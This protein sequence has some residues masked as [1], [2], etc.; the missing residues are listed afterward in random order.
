MDGEGKPLIK[1]SEESEENI[2]IE[3]QHTS[4][5]TALLAMLLAAI[6]FGTNS[7]ILK[8]IHMDLVL[9]IQIRFLLQWV[10]NL[11]VVLYRWSSAVDIITR[12]APALF[13]ARIASYG[14]D[15]SPLR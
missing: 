5:L 3:P 13:R 2:D 9:V 10:F 15:D 8:L 11:S 7:A 14:D 1:K 4:H 6:C 12:A